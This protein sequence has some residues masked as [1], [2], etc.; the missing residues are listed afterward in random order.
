M[1]LAQNAGRSAGRRLVISA[2]ST[3][4]SRSAQLAPA[5]AAVRDRA[6]SDDPSPHDAGLDQQPRGM[7][8]RSHGLARSHEIVHEADRVVIETQ[9]IPG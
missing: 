5:S 3:Q 8:D 1:S 4:T 7:A 6:R 9:M 2:P